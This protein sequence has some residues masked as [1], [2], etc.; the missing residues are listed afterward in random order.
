MFEDFRP[1]AHRSNLRGSPRSAGAKRPDIFI[2]KSD[3][4]KRS[5]ELDFQKRGK[6]SGFGI[7][8]A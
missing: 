8:E 3:A 7:P 2:E 1:N 6:L 5:Q 4:R